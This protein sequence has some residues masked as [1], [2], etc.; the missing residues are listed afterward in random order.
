MND[1]PSTENKSAFNIALE[2]LRRIHNELEDAKML[3]RMGQIEEWFY[4]CENLKRELKQIINQPQEQTLSQKR[5]SARIKLNKYLTIKK[6]P[7]FNEN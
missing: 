3:V 7:E 1:E 4:C 5:I 6:K 2:S